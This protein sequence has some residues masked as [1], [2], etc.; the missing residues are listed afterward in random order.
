MSEV[1]SSLNS[2][3]LPRLLHFLNN[4]VAHSSSGWIAN[5]DGPSIADFVLVP[6]LRWL[7]TGE[8]DGIGTNILD[9]FPHLV[10]L[11]TRLLAL[12]AIAN[13]YHN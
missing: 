10:Q 4:F 13:Y 3:V 2:E 1:R 9:K 8:I 11:I 5:T 12:P 6:R 7:A